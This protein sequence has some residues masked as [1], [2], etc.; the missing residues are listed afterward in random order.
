[1]NAP[2]PPGFVHEAPDDAELPYVRGCLLPVSNHFPPTVRDALVAASRTL[3]TF[4]PMARAKAINK[5]VERARL[6]H[7]NLFR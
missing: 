3:T 6:V 4:D 2:L 1:M 7:P 5:V